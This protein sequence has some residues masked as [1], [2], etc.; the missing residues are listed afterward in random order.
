MIFFSLNSQ[1]L[2]EVFEDNMDAWMGEFHKFLCYDNPAL[3]A[4]DNKDRE[5]AG[6]V[7]Q[8]KAAYLATMS[9]CTSRRTRKSS[10]GS[11]RRSCRTSGRC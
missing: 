10:R 6:A 1:E 2:P 7:D 4:V 5:K 3:A 8:V 9:T 11:S